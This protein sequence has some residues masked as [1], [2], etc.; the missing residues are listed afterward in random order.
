MCESAISG[1]HPCH[2]NGRLFAVVGDLLTPKVA[3]PLDNTGHKLEPGRG[4]G[5]HFSFPAYS[6]FILFLNETVTVE[7]MK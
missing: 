4:W 2:F 1:G 7:L 5:V 3:V 6:F